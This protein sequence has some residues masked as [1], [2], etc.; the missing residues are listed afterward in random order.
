MARTGI[1]GEKTQNLGDSVKQS[2]GLPNRNHPKHSSPKWH[3]MASI[4]EA[5]TQ[6]I[7]HPIYC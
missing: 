3:Q 5:I 1:M 7:N 2:L 6:K 4:N